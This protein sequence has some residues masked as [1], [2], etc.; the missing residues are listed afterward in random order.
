[1]T[2]KPKCNLNNRYHIMT[3]RHTT[4]CT[5]VNSYTADTVTLMLDVLTAKSNQF[6]YDPSKPNL[7]IW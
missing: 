4:T 2:I 1:M 7:Q 3:N 6:I 5:E